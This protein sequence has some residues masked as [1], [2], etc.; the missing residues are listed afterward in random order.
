MAAGGTGITGRMR[1]LL[2]RRSGDAAPAETSAETPD[3]V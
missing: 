1:G 3:A 2:G